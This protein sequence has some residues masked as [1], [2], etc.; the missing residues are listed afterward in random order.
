ML[1][2]L[3]EEDQAYAQ[4][5]IADSL[6]KLS[7]PEEAAAAYLKIPYLY[8]KSGQLPVTAQL[9]A[10]RVYERMGDVSAA[11][12]LYDKVI[13]QYGKG[14]QWGAEAQRRLQVIQSKTD[15]DS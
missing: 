2:L 10:A 13:S 12:R 7:R 1:P 6:E 3:G 4:F 11:V 14:S 15:A 5:W 9:K 8:P